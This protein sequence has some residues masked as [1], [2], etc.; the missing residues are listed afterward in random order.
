MD[1]DQLD[2]IQKPMINVILPKMG[3]SSKTCQYVL[4]F[5]PCKYLGIGG[6]DL[7]TERGMQQT[8]MFMKHI[9]SDQDLSKLRRIGLEWSQLPAG[10]ARPI[11]ECPSLEIPYLKLGWFRTL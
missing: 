10:I 11:L 9:R 8:L 7:V 2:K 3:Y 6:R 1:L 5:G 4:V